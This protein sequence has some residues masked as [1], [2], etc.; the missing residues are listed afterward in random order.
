M[1]FHR[2]KKHIIDIIFPVSLFLVFAASALAVIL[3]AANVYR[4]TAAASEDNYR[5]GTVLSYMTEK[6]HQNDTGG[7]ISVGS[8]DGRDSLVID[9]TYDSKDYVTYIYEDEGLL[10]ELFIQNGVDAFAADGS[11]IMPVTDFT[12]NEISDGLFEFSCL[13][14]DGQ[15]IS[16]I[17]A[18]KSK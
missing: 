3:L 4:D 12:M 18:A 10:R 1:R 6:I 9:Q 15:R 7:Q 5:T 11:E 2:E 8:F 14:D 16:T 13:S 17:V